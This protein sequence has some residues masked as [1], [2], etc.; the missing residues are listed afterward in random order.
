[1]AGGGDNLCPGV[2]LG[3]LIT[4]GTGKGLDAVI[5]T[6]GFGGHYT[7]I[8]LVGVHIITAARCSSIFKAEK[9]NGGIVVFSFHSNGVAYIAILIGDKTQ[10][11]GLTSAPICDRF[12]Q[13]QR[14]DITIFRIFKCIGHTTAGPSFSLSIIAVGAVI[15]G[16]CKSI[17]RSGMCHIDLFRICRDGHMVIRDTII[18]TVTGI[19]YSSLILNFA[20]CTFIRSDFGKRRTLGNFRTGSGVIRVC[21]ATGS[22]GTVGVAMTGGIYSFGIAVATG[23]GKGTLAIIRT[24]GRSGDFAF[25]VYMVFSIIPEGKQTDSLISTTLFLQRD[26]HTVAVLVNSITGDRSTD[27]L[28]AVIIQ[29]IG[30]LE[31][32]ALDGGRGYQIDICINHGCIAIDIGAGIKNIGIRAVGHIH[33]FSAARHG[34]IVIGNFMDVIVIILRLLLFISIIVTHLED[35]LV[36]NGIRIQFL[37]ANGNRQEGIS[38]LGFATFA[39]SVFKGQKITGCI[40]GIICAVPC[41][42]CNHLSHIQL[43]GMGISCCGRFMGTAVAGIATVIGTV[44]DPGTGKR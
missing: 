27:G 15:T 18:G 4:T 26:G 8:V 5:L 30:I 40:V 36:L 34:D 44:R 1:M 28:R 38:R 25:T 39:F 19:I 12:T 42:F 17:L 16:I 21:C 41:T 29:G 31:G 13:R 6:S 2:S 37:A 32:S 3:I 35:A 9:A 11:A 7:L 33:R 14:D 10:F 20:H 23:T 43:N 24:G 22:T